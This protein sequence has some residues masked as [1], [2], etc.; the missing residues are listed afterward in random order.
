MSLKKTKIF[1]LEDFELTD[2]LPPMQSSLENL[3][4]QNKQIVSVQTVEDSIK[5]QI[6]SS[7]GLSLNKSIEIDTLT[8]GLLQE[9]ESALI[10]DEPN[11]DLF[12]VISNIILSFHYIPEIQNEQGFL[13]EVIQLCIKHNKGHFLI[14]EMVDIIEKACLYELERKN[15]EVLEDLFSFYTEYSYSDFS[16]EVRRLK[17]SFL[18]YYWVNVSDNCESISNR[19]LRTHINE[20]LGEDS[21]M[22]LEYADV[23]EGIDMNRVRECSR[24]LLE[25]SKNRFEEWLSGKRISKESFKKLGLKNF[26]QN[27]RL[28][29]EPL[30]HSSVCDFRLNDLIVRDSLK[31]LRV[32]LQPMNE[33]SKNVS[34]TIESLRQ[35]SENFYPIGAKIHFKEPLSQHHKELLFSQF[36]FESTPFK[37]IHADS[38]MLLPPRKSSQ[39]LIHIIESLFKIGV[40]DADMDL[41]LQPCI[42]GRLNNQY[43][44][45]LGSAMIFSSY[46]C[47]TYEKNSFC[48]SHDEITGARIMAYDDGVLDRTIGN[49]PNSLIGRTDMLG[50][51]DARDLYLYQVLGSLVS[52]SVYGGPLQIIG[53]RFIDDYISLLN[54]HELLHI[55]EGQWI[56]NK[57]F[58]TDFG[59]ESH[60]E[61]IKTCTDQ[62]LSDFHEGSKTGLIYQVRDLLTKYINIIESNRHYKE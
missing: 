39:E 60:Y 49:L 30:I 33:I 59:A 37:M 3:S 32:V 31:S 44:G 1:R 24:H 12:K 50:R 2:G 58:D 7:C 47:V 4:V 52:Q 20:I 19:I 36:N 34:K 11:I 18:N 26:I 41:D 51:R 13:S 8:T 48:T 21:P 17:E 9:L 27:K 61:L 38:S 40:L 57:E 55:L 5:R 53:K 42:P 10:K 25:Q 23:L 14:P 22:A 45:I 56:Y 15:M 35:G 28:S 62:W 43:A 6:F 29:N 46:T 54:Q 16:S